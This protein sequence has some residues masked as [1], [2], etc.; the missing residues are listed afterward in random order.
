MGLKFA[1]NIVNKFDGMCRCTV[2]NIIDQEELHR[3][4]MESMVELILVE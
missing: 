4:N 1:Y 3:V 2:E